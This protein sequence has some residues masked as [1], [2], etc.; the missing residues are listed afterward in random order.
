MAL[1]LMPD[2]HLPWGALEWDKDPPP[3]EWDHALAAL[4]GHPLQSCLWGDA[5]RAV[6]GTVQHRWLARRGGEPIW[7]IRVE[8]RKV[9]GGKI[10]WAPRGP[11][12][13]TAEMSL[14][15]PPG[16]EERLRAEGFA[17]LICDPWVEDRETAQPY[18]KAARTKPQTIWID[19]S[20]GKDAVF[21]NLHK[22]VR[23]GVRRAAKTGVNVETTCDPDR[24]REF[25]DLCS[26]ISVRKG[27]ELRATSDFVNTLLKSSRSNKDAEAVLFVSLKEGK[28]G[29]GLL[30]LRVGQSV[31]MTFAGTN[32]DLRQERVG[33]ACQWGVMEWAIT[34]GCTRYDL[35]G[36]DPA[37]NASVY[38][39]KKRLG[40]EE[41]TL[42]GHIHLPL[43]FSGRAMSWLVRL[44]AH[45]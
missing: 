33:E 38:E 12:G 23:N 42:R 36:I 8:E 6:D 32:R 24:I 5:R 18:A 2:T 21:S 39:F 41:I 22:H 11:T 26:S 14:S 40:G 13:R 16:F 1:D 37:N 31:H 28:L 43:K 15:V 35:E 45:G 4:C 34:R 7:M 27:F 9:P 20:A 19:L 17:L 3:A 29:A 44:G 30:A 25:A 10:A